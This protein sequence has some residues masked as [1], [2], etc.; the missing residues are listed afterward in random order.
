MFVMIMFLYVF[1]AFIVFLDIAII[2]IF[3]FETLWFADSR[4][5]VQVGPKLVGFYLKT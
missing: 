2:I 4:V 1:E 3:L 5:A